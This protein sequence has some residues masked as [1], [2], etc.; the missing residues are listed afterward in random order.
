MNENQNTPGKSSEAARDTSKEFEMGK[1]KPTDDYYQVD[2]PK[3]DFVSSIGDGEMH[4]EGLVGNGDLADGET[5]SEGST[6]EQDNAEWH[7]SEG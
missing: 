7:D 3:K 1:D 2:H 5:F 4:N 6:S